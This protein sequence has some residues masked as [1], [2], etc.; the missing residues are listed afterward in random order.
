MLKSARKQER[1]PKPVKDE[2]GRMSLGDHLR[3]LRNRLAKAVL[4]IVVV[5]VVAAV[6]NEEIYKF[7]TAPFNDYLASVGCSGDAVLANDGSRCPS[8]VQT[9]VLGPF[10]N[11]MK[12]V[13]MAA[14]VGAAPVW[15]YQIWAFV[16]PGLHRHEK[17]YAYGF[18]A[19]GTPLFLV[20]GW[21]AYAILPQTFSVLLGF[22]NESTQNLPTLEAYLDLV[23]RM[24]VVF[25]LAFEL[26][27]FLVALNFI[28]LVSGKRM[29]GWWRGM[30][31]GLTVFAAFA[32]PGGEPIS[33]L[34]LAGSLSVLYFIAVGVALVNDKRRALR[35]PDAGLSEDEASEIDL[36]PDDI[37]EIESVPAARALPEA[38]APERVN[39][40][41][42]I[43]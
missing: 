24:V 16:A 34:I 30:V 5:G 8:L 37:G 7:L 18:V 20:G 36:R 26:P 40:Y 25:G 14:V 43:T 2:E 22:T 11:L 13:L 21:L 32:T 1:S 19:A 42:D 15:L 12:I 3:E 23:T 39:A 35:N 31:M 6:F 17:R 41:D 27:L 28:G 9:D 29:A 38:S 33:M 4:A 10:T